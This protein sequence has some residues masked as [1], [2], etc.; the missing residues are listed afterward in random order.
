MFKLDAEPT[1]AAN[2][3]LVKP[4]GAAT[5]VRAVFRYRDQ[6][7]YNALLEEMRG[8]ASHE[9][10]AALLDDW[11]EQDDEQGRWEGMGVPFSAAALQDLANRYPRAVGAFLD[12][13]L[14]ETLGLPLKN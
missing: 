10:V 6:A 14:H 7:G 13:Y 12:V 5:V 2:V 4:G 3:T 8:K 9:F 1:F 11:H